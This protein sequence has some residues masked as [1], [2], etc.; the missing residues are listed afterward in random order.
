M[1][2]GLFWR[3]YVWSYNLEWHF[4]IFQFNTCRCYKETNSNN[5]RGNKDVYDGYDVSLTKEGRKYGQLQNL[6][7][8]DEHAK[9]KKKYNT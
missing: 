9:T 4:R 8:V 6:A 3:G 7:Y 1:M 5:F 2:Y